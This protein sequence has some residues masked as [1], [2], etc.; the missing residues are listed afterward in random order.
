MS[1]IVLEDLDDNYI[2]LIT[3]GHGVSHTFYPQHPHLQKE[4]SGTIR[5]LQSLVCGLRITWSAF[6]KMSIPRLYPRATESECLGLKSRNPRAVLH[7]VKL[8][9]IELMISTIPSGSKVT[10]SGLRGAESVT[11]GKRIL[12]EVGRMSG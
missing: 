6:L 10:T 9:A 4:E 11:E 8:T 12:T 1:K 2:N 5:V 7:A 3:K